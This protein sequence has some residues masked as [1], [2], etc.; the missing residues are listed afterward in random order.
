MQR[1]TRRHA[2]GTVAAVSSFGILSGRAQAAEFTYKY[3]NNQPLTH[4]MNIRAKEA[5]DKIKEESNGRLEIQIF[6]NN[7]LGGDTDMVS[8]VRSGAIDFFTVSGL[9]I[10]SFVPVAAANG[11]GYAF[12]NYDQVWAAMDGE[13][14][15]HIRANI[16]KSSVMAFDKIW[17]NGFRQMTHGTRP[18]NTPADLKGFKI[19]IPVM[20]IETSLFTRL[21]AAP[22]TVNI[23]EAYSA[24]QTH[25]VDGQE[26]PLAIIENWKFYEVQK[27]CSL[28][29]HMWDG[30]WMLAS[31]KTWSKLPADLQAIVT[32]NFNAAATNQRA[33]IRLLNDT[34]RTKLEER[35][36]VFNS[37][38]PEPFRE[39]L[40]TSGYYQ[41]W[42]GKFGDEA[43]ALL[44]KY[45]GKLA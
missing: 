6:P 30:F 42:K 20:A 36:M 35:G 27:Y 13:F 18:I 15:A 26:N 11:V 5:A 31:A 32:R 28:T 25:L 2:L 10:D 16:A 38:D 29:N 22:A 4:P 12:K 39:T 9:L 24:L 40:R 21:G 1:V 41:E 23:K 3:A 14:G 45:S 34:L 19:R 7:A 37:P 33:D 44:E 17:D 8:Q 43:W